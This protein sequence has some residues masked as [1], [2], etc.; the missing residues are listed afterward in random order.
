MIYVY[1]YKHVN[2]LLNF[3]YTCDS[4]VDARVRQGIFNIPR[5]FIKFNFCH[6]EAYKLNS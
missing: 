4:L 5:Y 1:V 2:R 6:T 3:V